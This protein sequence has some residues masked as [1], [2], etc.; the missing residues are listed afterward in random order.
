MWFWFRELDS[1]RQGN[2]YGMNSLG[3]RE[4]KA[5]AD[6]RELS[7]LPWHLDAILALDIKRRSVAATTAQAETEKPQA[8]V[9]KRS[10]TSKL[11]DAL[12]P[13][14]TAK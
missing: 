11:F 2:G 6:L 9:S 10:L 13:D 7:L 1:Q 5:W 3:F 8:E 4:I 12:F 14:R